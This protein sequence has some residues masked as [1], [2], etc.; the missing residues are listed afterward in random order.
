M[1]MS[2]F[3]NDEKCS[4]IVFCDIMW[5]GQITTCKK[6]PLGLDSPFT[7]ESMEHTMEAEFPR[8]PPKLDDDICA[9]FSTGGA[10]YR[11]IQHL[12]VTIRSIRAANDLI[13]KFDQPAPEVAA[14][15]DDVASR[16][17]RMFDAINPIVSVGPILMPLGDLEVPLHGSE[18]RRKVTV[19]VSPP[20]DNRARSEWN[21]ENRWI[22]LHLPKYE[23]DR[24]LF[25][26][27]DLVD[28]PV[29]NSLRRECF[30]AYMRQK[31]YDLPY[32]LD[33]LGNAE[34]RSVEERM[35]SLEEFDAEG[36]A[37]WD[38]IRVAKRFGPT[39]VT[40][41]SKSLENIH[42]PYC[43]LPRSLYHSMEHITA[44]LKDPMLR[45]IFI[46]RVKNELSKLGEAD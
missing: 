16:V 9:L 27:D 23:I 35:C 5:L 1:G 11:V 14:H 36:C 43:E 22:V 45:P 41:L 3:L 40:K 6:T 37:V 31:R 25:T 2:A 4:F 18:E 26:N 32:D 8:L 13:R 29:H 42:D 10:A 28:D 39:E 24:N 21:E 44:W 46:E 12:H 33:L 38:S 20:A 19:F 17:M 15:C 7:N 34:R 30:H